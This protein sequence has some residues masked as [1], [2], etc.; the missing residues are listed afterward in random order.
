MSAYG[1]DL[2]EFAET[3][4]QVVGISTDSI[5]S[6]IAWQEKGIGWQE[7]PLASDYWPH[8]GIAEKYGILRLGEPLPGINDR[9]VFVVDKNGKIVFSKVYELG[10]EPDNEEYL[11]VLREMRE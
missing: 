1:R 11:K 7:Y 9:A 4:A 3:N 10:Q 5:Y 6:H 8:G 2:P